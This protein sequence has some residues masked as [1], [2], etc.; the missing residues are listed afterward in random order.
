MA[1]CLT[2][3]R[4]NFTATCENRIGCVN[5]KPLMRHLSRF[6]AEGFHGSLILCTP[7]VAPVRSA[8]VSAA[9]SGKRETR[10]GLSPAGALSGQPKSIA[11]QVVVVLETKDSRQRGSG[12]WSAA[13]RTSA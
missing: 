10:I 8:S 2:R 5:H 7:P 11:E 12:S 3:R 9:L 13:S 4:G 6:G 1:L